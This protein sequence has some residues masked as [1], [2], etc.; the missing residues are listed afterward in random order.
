MFVGPRRAIIFLELAF[1]HGL[2]VSLLILFTMVSILVTASKKY[3]FNNKNQDLSLID[4]AWIISFVNFL[5]IHMFDITYFDGRISILSWTLLAG[6][7]KIS[8]SES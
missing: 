7:R 1:N 8:R 6:L 3:F 5:I 2:I 4:K